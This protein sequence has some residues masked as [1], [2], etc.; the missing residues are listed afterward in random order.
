[1]NIV[2]VRYVREVTC[3]ECGANLVLDDDFVF[4]QAAVHAECDECKCEFIMQARGNA[5]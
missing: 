4:V 2:Q 1:M 3:P 5:G